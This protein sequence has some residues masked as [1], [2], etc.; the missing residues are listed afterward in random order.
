[1]SESRASPEHRVV[2]PGRLATIGVCLLALVAVGCGNGPDRGRADI[3]V[4][5]RRHAVGVTNLT[6][7][8][9]AVSCQITRI[10]ERRHV[11]STV[12]RRENL[13]GTGATV[14]VFPHRVVRA[15]CVDV[16]ADGFADD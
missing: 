9:V 4:T 12:I 3:A 1:V 6:D 8:V 2:G 15:R 14:W 13:I 16:S 11:N 5:A 10:L 7:D